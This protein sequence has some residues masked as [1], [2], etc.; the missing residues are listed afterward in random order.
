[1]QIT[2]GLQKKAPLRKVL[3][4][5]LPL[6]IGCSLG[7][8][9]AI[10]VPNRIERNSNN[11]VAVV[12]EV[13]SQAPSGANA[14]FWR[15]SFSELT[16]P[17]SE[18]WS[19][20]LRKT[21]RNGVVEAI[22]G[23]NDESWK[24]LP[25][26]PSC[27]IRLFGALRAN[28]SN[29]VA[30]LAN[31]R[32]MGGALSPSVRKELARFAALGIGLET[33]GNEGV[34]PLLLAVDPSLVPDF[35]YGFALGRRNGGLENDLKLADTI[36]ARL[37][38][39]DKLREGYRIKLRDAVLDAWM[40]RSPAVL[41]KWL[42]SK[43]GE[44]DRSR[45]PQVIS[46]LCLQSADSGVGFIG[47]QSALISLEEFASAFSANGADASEVKKVC[48]QLGSA[49]ASQFLEA[50]AKSL[51]Q[52]SPRSVVEFI[53]AADEDLVTAAVAE[54]LAPAV[55]Q[56]SPRLLLRLTA[57]L[58]A[59]ERG[60]IADRCFNRANQDTLAEQ[61]ET[62]LRLQGLDGKFSTFA[63]NQVAGADLKAAIAFIDQAPIEKREQ[64]RD[65][66]F[67]STINTRA[68]ED[69]PVSDILYYI[70]SLP[71]DR[72][73]VLSKQMAFTLGLWNSERCMEVLVGEFK[74]DPGVW[75]AVFNGSNS[76]DTA[77]MSVSDMSKL[78]ARAIES[79]VSPEVYSVAAAGMIGS[80]AR[81]DISAAQREFE[82]LAVSDQVKE[83]CR[84]AMIEVWSNSDPLAASD[85]VRQLPVGEARDRAISAILPHIGFALEEREAL[86]EL[87]SSPAS[88][89]RMRSEI[90]RAK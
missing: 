52:M 30:A 35:L 7:F 39:A 70:N 14:N 74:N 72:R 12:P 48:K 42:R 64:L 88:Q 10:L 69:R 76:S 87:A 60:D 55:A 58:P 38:H 34:D 79:G 29:E 80:L 66:V 33:V 53:E 8:S 6:V 86:I 61:G 41:L 65:S 84:E 44:A 21:P 37:E 16:L 17:L 82:N 67:S 24:T 57:N 71:P 22:R 45:I 51:A 36:T 54:A 56:I 89:G 23:L 13:G 49:S 1:M 81:V 62:Y 9:S 90:S 50:Y 68:Y 4:W 3:R 20:W 63:L 18:S 83:R 19:V 77:R 46:F 78:L 28:G 43:E 47:D 11:V 2:S 27:S 15:G 40:K 5:G 25:L 59:K 85:Y 32:F 31:E 75:S 26:A 73:Q